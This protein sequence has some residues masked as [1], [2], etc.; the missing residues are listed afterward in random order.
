MSG[1]ARVTF[2][3]LAIDVPLALVLPENSSFIEFLMSARWWFQSVFIF[4]PKIGEMIQFDEH[5]FQRGWKAP[6]SVVAQCFVRFLSLRKFLWHLFLLWNGRFNGVL[7]LF[8]SGFPS[9]KRC[10]FDPSDVKSSKVPGS[11][12]ANRLRRVSKTPQ[13]FDQ[14]PKPGSICFDFHLMMGEPPF[15][16]MNMSFF[17]SEIADYWWSKKEKCIFTYTQ[18]IIHFWILGDS[19]LASVENGASDSF[20]WRMGAV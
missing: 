5:I 3:C 11:K 9:K 4:T 8:S 18:Y 10:V 12:W 2:R 13:Q 6:T 7:L 19:V 14:G 15:Y 1:K 20:F 17:P 16:H